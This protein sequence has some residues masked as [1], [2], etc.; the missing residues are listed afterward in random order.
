MKLLKPILSTLLA[1]S[2]VFGAALPAYA[3]KPA[4]SLDELL[5]QVKQGRYQE[6]KENRAREQRFRADRN[7]QAALLKKA[8]A[9]RLAQ[10]RLSSKLE[11][12][13]ETNDKKMGE[14]EVRLKNKMGNLT[15]LFGHITT[16]AGD[17][18]GNFE[19]SLTSI[20]YPNR[21]EGLDKLI[22]KASSGTE[23]PSIEEIEGLWYELQREMT[24][25]GN[26]VK[27][28]AEVT[29][30]NGEKAQTQVVRV[31]SFNV[32]TADGKYLRFNHDS[33]VL[34]E[35]PRQPSSRYTD[36][37][38]SL[39]SA[40]SGL[41]AFGVD[42][43][44]PAGGSLLAALINSPTLKERWEQGGIVG[45]V[46][47]ALGAI[48]LL[49]ALWRILTLA[50]VS[51]KVKS[52]LKS[53][54]AKTNN[55][56]GRVLKVHEDNPNMDSETLELKLNEAVLKELPKL[57]GWLSTLKIIAA[58]A[59]LLGLLGTVTGMIITFQAI[60]VFGAGD[61]KAMAD[62]ISSA[63]VTTVL[64]LIVAIP[65]VLLH[66]WV[67]GRSRAL[68]HVLEEQSAGLIAEHNEANSKK[69]V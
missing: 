8:K 51:M 62:G 26:I 54:E 33:Q 66:T 27:F 58:V 7:Q 49:I 48:A 14:E 35:L 50:F 31:G 52:Q 1:T 25:S 41:S 34:E 44:G 39:A 30:P 61:P 24:E 38:S 69:S 20:H 37:A 56:L 53:K 46:I 23:L 68:V 6:N 57:E 21:D 22:E 3:N 32:V 2:F 13:F 59:P 65:T 40:N 55:P 47:T 16:A 9:D 64:G 29:K 18:R 63:L 45:K 15:E 36:K 19:S 60:T 11:A 5:R 43:T 28:D 17:A 10:E 42:P 12:K 4:A 67:S